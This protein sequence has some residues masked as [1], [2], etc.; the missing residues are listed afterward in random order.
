MNGVLPEDIADG[1]PM[2]QIEA[3]DQAR[4]AEPVWSDDQL[5]EHLQGRLD[6]CLSTLTPLEEREH[7][8]EAHS[9]QM[10]KLHETVTTLDAT[11]SLSRSL[12]ERHMEAGDV[13]NAVAE[14]QRLD[15]AVAVR[16]DVVTRR[17]AEQAA[18][19]GRQ[20]EAI[21]ALVA[22][23]DAL[24]AI[25]DDRDQRASILA[26]T[27]AD[28]EAAR[29]RIIR[30]AVEASQAASERLNP[31]AEQRAERLAADR[32]AHADN[33]EATYRATHGG[34]G[35][36]DPEPVA[37]KRSSNGAVV[38]L[39]MLRNRQRLDPMPAIHMRTGGTVVAP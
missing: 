2:W 10:R 19:A 25:L 21:A 9:V 38:A 13:G 5:V 4:V 26:G 39:E 30:R 34:R 23:R 32:Q 7:A 27:R 31:T 24:Q 3:D 1:R 14:R 17:D 15:A 29:S 28:V 22:E 8:I 20:T 6:A 35:P 18:T 16:E 11:I 37:R 12:I 36:D 33:V